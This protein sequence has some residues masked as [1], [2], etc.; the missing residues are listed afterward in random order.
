M[1][2]LFDPESETGSGDL[3]ES[4]RRLGTSLADLLHTRADLLAVEL[5]EEKLRFIRL[6]VWL[7]V[8]VTFGVAGL[9]IVI[10][11]L[12]LFVWEVAGYWGLAGLAAGALG[13]A[14]IILWI[15]HRGITRGPAPFSGTVAEFRKD[16]ECLHLRK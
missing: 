12:A 1:S 13:L 2:R 6:I 4:V 7:A 10:G 8:A 3:M 5:Q 9:L 15:V 16:T 14:A 11:G